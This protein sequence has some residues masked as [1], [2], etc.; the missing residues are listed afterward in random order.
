MSA[1]SVARPSFVKTF[2]RS[3]I[4]SAVATGV[5]WALLF[6]LVEFFHVWYVL[7]TALGALV[8]AITNFL[9]NRHWSFE[10]THRGLQGQAA[11]YAAISGASM[12]LN[13]LGV[14]AMTEWTRIHYSISVFVISIA[15][16]F[17]FNY[18]LHRY[19][20]FK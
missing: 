19:W 2:T 10:A 6:A 15:V 12:T 3:Q 17:L 1:P 8:G 11:R 4:A 18:P 20:V 7:A 16:G 14:W 5:D 13:T 9:M